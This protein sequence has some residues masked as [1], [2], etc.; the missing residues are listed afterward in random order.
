M[1]SPEGTWVSVT[2]KLLGSSRYIA[3]VAC[4]L[5]CC[6][7]ST[8]KTHML[9]VD[10]RGASVLRGQDFDQDNISNNMFTCKIVLNKKTSMEPWQF[11]CP[12][13]HYQVCVVYYQWAEHMREVQP[14]RPQYCDPS[15]SIARLMKRLPWVVLI[16]AGFGRPRRW[17]APSSLPPDDWQQTSTPFLLRENFVHSREAF[18]E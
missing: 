1:S 14:S 18:A 6:S 13:H 8:H 2:A 10:G 7:E 12:G 17:H 15:C 16:R 3:H 5:G 11:T 4:F 9:S